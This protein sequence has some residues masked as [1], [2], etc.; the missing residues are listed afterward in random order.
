VR[1]GAGATASGGALS[2]W[3]DVVGGAHARLG[4][5]ADAVDGVVPAWVV[6]PGSVREVQACLVAAAARGAAVVATGCGAHLDVGAPPVRVDV[7]LRLDRL[8]R[9]LD[10]QAGDMTVTAEA[11]CR[12]DVLAPVLA[13]AGQ[14]LPLDPPRPAAT[15]LGGLVAA[16]LSGPL[17]A[18]QGRVRDLLLGLRVVDATGA[19][20]SGGGRVV[21]NVAGYDLP[22]LHVGALGTVGVI[23]ET[24]FKVRPR[25]AH[26]EA[27]VI[28]CPR[29]ADA[30]STAEAALDAPTPPFWLE[31]AGPDA[32]PE[33]PGDGAAVVAGVAGV[34]EEVADGRACLLTLARARGLCA[35]TVADAAALRARLADF[36]L[37][38][39][40]AVLRAS[41]LPAEVGATMEAVVAA[42]RRV[43]V[44][45]RVLAH[46][47]N[48]VVRAAVAV[49][50]GV[51]DLVRALRPSL[52]ARGGALVVE[53]AAPEVKRGLDVWGDVG[54]ALP[55]MRRLKRAFDPD[56]VLAPGR[57][58]GGI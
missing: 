5:P 13:A 39:A 50:D 32:V 49:P 55:L 41:T 4:T 40:A 9:V 54:A 52:E 31:V 57:Y 37:E 58:V 47:A 43:G 27:V 28:A 8:G 30:A 3:A 16:D 19:L 24:T 25:P 56:A 7:L 51:G 26:E 20:V 23:V 46:A 53:R 11:G 14:W 21:K 17:R 6:C 22:K 38:P 15:T 34:A 18:S 12:L 33:G 42:A 48:G 45:V 35:L 29:V 2:T 44:A 1:G 36:A 10:H